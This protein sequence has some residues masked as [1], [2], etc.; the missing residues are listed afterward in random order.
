MKSKFFAKAALFKILC[1]TLIAHTIPTES[2]SIASTPSKLQRSPIAFPDTVAGRQTEKW[3]RAFNS[4]DYEAIRA[5]YTGTSPP[6]NVDEDAAYAYA[7]YL[8][9]RGFDLYRIEQGTEYELTFLASEK[10]SGQWDVVR[11]QYDE[12]EPYRQTNFGVGYVYPPSDITSSGK[13]SAGEIAKQLDLLMNKLAAKDIYSG[14]VLV[15]KDDKV[16]SKK[17]YGLASK[18]YGVRNRTD[19]KFNIGSITKVF[20]AVAV[21]QLA[22]QGKLALGDTI[23]KYLPDYS[24]KAVSEKVTIHQLLTHTSGI[25]RQARLSDQGLALRPRLRTVSAWFQLFVDRPPEFEAGARWRYSNEGYIVLGAIIEKVSGQTYFD[26]VK[27]RVFKPA[28]MSNTDFYELDSDT[29]N[30]ATGY[31]RVGVTARALLESRRNNSLL[32]FVKGQSAGGAYST[33]E[34]LLKFKIALFDHKL[35]NRE[36]TNFVVVGK[37]V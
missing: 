27:E 1:L 16:I 36:Y 6:R 34:D 28:G 30:L 12:K 22:Q 29:P 7:A 24:N 26:Y 8:D 3:L 37:V 4:G 14:A 11:L 15:A 5:F 32:N 20:T 23:S 35:L 31:T 17:A 10:V 13:M 2:S 21:L 33:V 9:T 19:T 25:G 18:A